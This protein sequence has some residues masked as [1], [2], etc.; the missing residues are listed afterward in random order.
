MNNEREKGNIKPRKFHTRT[1]PKPDN[2]GCLH[3]NRRQKVAKPISIQSASHKRPLLHFYQFASDTICLNNQVSVG[4][5]N[6]EYHSDLNS[7]KNNLKHY[8][9]KTGH[10]IDFK[11][12]R[13]IS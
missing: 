3:K 11:S 2:W 8:S 4:T 1:T 6:R 13:Q 9:Y 10:R 12:T 5:G 7:K